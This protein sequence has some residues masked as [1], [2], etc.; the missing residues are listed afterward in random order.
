MAEPY[1]FGYSVGGNPQGT[2]H[3]A[4][5]RTLAGVY[6]PCVHGHWAVRMR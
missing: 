2:N 4:I 5:S 6:V 3:V 1:R